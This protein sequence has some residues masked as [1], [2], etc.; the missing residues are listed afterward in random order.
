V[1]IITQ[2]QLTMV[3]SCSHLQWQVLLLVIKTFCVNM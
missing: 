1:M 3:K 2:Q